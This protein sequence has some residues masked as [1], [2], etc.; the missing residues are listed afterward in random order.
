MISFCFPF[1]RLRQLN[2]PKRPDK[3]LWALWPNIN[4]IL[5]FLFWDFFKK[6]LNFDFGLYFDRW[7]F[8]LWC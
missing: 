1:F 4:G 2:L 3:P 5:G 8:K 6:I 7:V